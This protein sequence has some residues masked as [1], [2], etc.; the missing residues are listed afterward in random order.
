MKIFKIVILSLVLIL[1]PALTWAIPLKA[2]KPLVLRLYDEIY[3]S[4]AEPIVNALNA[5][6]P[7]DVII[8]DIFSP[9]GTFVDGLRIIDAM[10]ASKARVITVVQNMAASMAT[11]IALSSKYIIISE[12][13]KLHFHVG[14]FFLPDGMVI[15]NNHN[16]NPICVSSIAQILNAYSY[17]AG[18]YLTASE[19]QSIFIGNDLWKNAN[20]FKEDDRLH[21]MR[22]KNGHWTVNGWDG[23]VITL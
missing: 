16:Y 10:R 11:I 19:K 22:F 1:G 2:V 20:Q 4:T 8:I 6:Q 9:G 15:C 23:E 5:A 12:R 18:K 14:R 7:G 13:A 21:I 17:G 3:Y